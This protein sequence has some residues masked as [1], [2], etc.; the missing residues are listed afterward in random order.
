MS[1]RGATVGL[2]LAL[3]AGIAAACGYC[4]EDKIAA[5]Y[6]HAVLTRAI[7]QK[8]SVVFFHIDGSVPPGDAGRRWLET[9]AESTSG[10]DRGSVRVS[11]DTFS[12]SFAFD[13][14]AV[15]LSRVQASLEKKLAAKKLS[16]MPLRVMDRPAELKTVGANP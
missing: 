4:V 10:V 7:A 16:L 1:A 9:A 8:H 3:Q 14:K 15:P 6:D 13:P 5:T 11:V 2:V 12:V